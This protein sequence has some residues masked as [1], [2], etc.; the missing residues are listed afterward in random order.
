MEPEDL[1][2]YNPFDLVEKTTNRL[3]HWEQSG[4]T[5]F[6]TFRLA[7]A[8]PASLRAQWEE[9]R[10]IWM[11]CHPLPWD[12][13]TQ[14]EYHQRFSAQMDAWLDAGHGECLLKKAACR[15]SVKATLQFADDRL[16][17]LHAWVVMPNHV[18][19]LASMHEGSRL[20]AVIHSWK[21]ASVHAINKHLGRKG[22]LWQED[23][24]DR[25]VRDGDHFS[26]CVRYI[27]RNPAKAGLRE[28]SFSHYESEL[29]LRFAPVEE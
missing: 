6:I 10:A 3:T 28:G 12:L 17:H 21:G 18:H 1:K 5:Y 27:R 11:S 26:A 20:E 2:F 9:E 29:A 15:V 25:L 8:V 4:R 23:Y 14:K 19:V 24:F 22:R 13:Q 16:Y 7:D